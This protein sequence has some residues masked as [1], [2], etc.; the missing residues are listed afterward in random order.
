MFAWLSGRI[1]GDMLSPKYRIVLYILYPESEQ[2]WMMGD[3]W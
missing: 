2:R 3:E 1:N